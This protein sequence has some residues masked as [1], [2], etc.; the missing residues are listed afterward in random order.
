MT[1]PRLPS[2]LVQTSKL[3][4]GELE[5][6]RVAL[7]T[8][9]ARP[10]VSLLLYGRDGVRAVPLVEGRPLVIGREPPADVVLRDASLS[11]LHAEVGLEAGEVYVQDLGSTNGTYLS[12]ERVDRATA[13]PREE[14]VFGTVGASVHVLEPTD[15]LARGLDGHDRFRLELESEVA[16]ARSFGRVLVLAMIRGADAGGAGRGNGL[17]RWL[18]EVRR[19]LRP[20]DR[21]ALYSPDTVEVLMPETPLH[22]ARALCASIVSSG[23]RLTCGLG[24]LP[25]SAGSAEELLEVTR[26]AMNRARLS[27]AVALQVATRPEPDVEI[28]DET[29]VAVSP[30]MVEVLARARRIAQ[31]SFPVL[32]VGETGSGKEVVARTIHR[33][34][35][36]RDRPMV[37]VNCGAIPEHLVESTLFGHERGAFTGAH[38]RSRGLF[39]S[40]HGGTVFLDEIGELPASAQAAL[41][42]VLETMRFSRVGSAEEVEVDVRVVAATHRD[43]PAM[44]LDGA[45]REDLLYRLD[46]VTL[47]VPPLRDRAED[48]PDLARRFLAAAAATCGRAFV[49]IDATAL[50]LLCRQPWPGNVRELRNAIEH[51]VAISD[52]EVLT[53]EDLPERIRALQPALGLSGSVRATPIPTPAPPGPADGEEGR[54]LRERV[55]RY[56]E[57]II[58]AA[59]RE[60]GWDRR[61]AARALD[62]PLSTLAH[63]MRGHGIRRAYQGRKPPEEP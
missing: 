26:D 14:L 2:D 50:D 7:A 13:R 39:E 1:T 62:L 35:P 55:R 24:D 43:L 16:R 25:G 22:E 27:D 4:P 54:D 5:R 45:F 41:L 15:G 56:E 31:T 51:A 8:S 36:R 42:R 34:G 10:Q 19:R 28:A 46:A 12:G 9:D 32:I 21:V 57:A 40:A 11:R 6:L 48:V 58:L 17:G 61:A 29:P 63:K 37:S 60:T 44:V 20:F 53:V 23:L 38:Q 47:V 33:C 59:L 30:G 18:P 52:A 49:A 3:G